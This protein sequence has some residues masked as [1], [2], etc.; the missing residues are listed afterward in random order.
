[1]KSGARS[2]SHRERKGKTGR[3]GGKDRGPNGHIDKRRLDWSKIQ[4]KHINLALY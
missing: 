4:K 1:M 3:V 2:V